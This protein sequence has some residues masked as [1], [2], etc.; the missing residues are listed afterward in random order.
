MTHETVIFL[1]KLYIRQE[2]KLTPTTS[3]T[4]MFTDD[5]VKSKIVEFQTAEGCTVEVRIRPRVGKIIS[6]TVDTDN[7][8]SFHTAEFRQVPLEDVFKK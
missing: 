1:A 7:K 8:A 3:K 2:L 4:T 6:K 5:D